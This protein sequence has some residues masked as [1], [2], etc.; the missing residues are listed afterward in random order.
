MGGEG[1]GHDEA[2]MNVFPFDDRMLFKHYFDGSA[3][4]AR[5]KQYY[6]NQQYRFEVPPSEFS[7]LR[8]FLADNGYALRVV[9]DVDAYVVVV[10]KYTNHP[11]NIFKDSVFQR[12]DGDYNF[13]LLKDRDAVEQATRNGATRLTHTDLERP[14]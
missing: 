9:R 13:F 3:V 11:E 14:F 12:G 5:L 7:E 1:P 8:E 10:Q 4:F 6:N 2:D